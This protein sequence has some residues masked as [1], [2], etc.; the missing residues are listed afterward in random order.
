MAITRQEVEKVALLA[1]LRLSEPE[2]EK[3]T[4]QLNQIV[5]FVQ[6][7]QDLDTDEVEPLAHPL[8]LHNVFRSDEVKP[9]IGADQALASAPKHDQEYYL[10]PAVLD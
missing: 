8:P 3:F 6:Q 1:R 4:S 5:D 9:S 7:L 2:L 10:V